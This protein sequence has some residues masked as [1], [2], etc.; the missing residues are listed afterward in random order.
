MKRQRSDRPVQQSGGN[1][2]L[3][4]KISLS[5]CMGTCDDEGEVG[6]KVKMS[7]RRPNLAGKLTLG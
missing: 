6:A 2:I 7:D 1:R 5:C 3:K 4:G